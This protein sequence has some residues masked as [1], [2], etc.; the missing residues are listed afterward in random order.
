MAK[1]TR[2]DS[3]V[4]RI[5]YQWILITTQRHVEAASRIQP[6]QAIEPGAVQIDK[7]GGQRR[8]IALTVKTFG[9][10]YP[11]PTGIKATISHSVVMLTGVLSVC[12]G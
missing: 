4:L 5:A 6:K 7:H 9:V 8:R 11:H 10:G 12:C 1:G 2:Y 3:E